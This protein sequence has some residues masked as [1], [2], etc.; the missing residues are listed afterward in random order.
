MATE[1]NDLKEKI[2]NIIILQKEELTKSTH[3]SALSNVN[4]LYYWAASTN[5][6]VFYETL[7][8]GI[9]K[10]M[11]EAISKHYENFQQAAKLAL[12][13][14]APKILEEEAENP[15]FNKEDFLTSYQ[16]NSET[17]FGTINTKLYHYPD[18]KQATVTQSVTSYRL[19]KG[20]KKLNR[21][22]TKAVRAALKD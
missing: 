1:L 22:L 3:L 6:D 18:V 5:N 17:D 14:L 13:D 11:V 10:E 2:K 9:T 15:D 12:I 7:P 19:A 21:K 8:E 20:H 4:V 16:I